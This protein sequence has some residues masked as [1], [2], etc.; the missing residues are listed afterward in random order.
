MFP[1]RRA[2]LAEKRR[3]EITM[4][5]SRAAVKRGFQLAKP[6]LESLSRKAKNEVK[7]ELRARFGR[8][9]NRINAIDASRQQ[10]RQR[11]ANMSPVARVA[12]RPMVGVRLARRSARRGAQRASAAIERGRQRA[13]NAAQGFRAN[14]SAALRRRRTRTA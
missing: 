3:L 9:Q 7:S 11:R 6:G 2:R 12:T 5:S 14:V 10:D 4:A 1:R 8:M 13:S